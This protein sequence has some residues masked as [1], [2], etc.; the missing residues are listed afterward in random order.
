MLS[1]RQINAGSNQGRGRRLLSHV[2]DLGYRLADLFRPLADAARWPFE[3]AF[4]AIEERVVWPLRERAA[5]RGPSRHATGIGAVAAGGLAAI[6]LAALLLPAGGADRKREGEPVRVAL[7]PPPAAQQQGE[8]PARRELQGPP[9]DF[10]VAGGVSAGEEGAGA[11]GAPAGS[12]SSSS[13]P[14]ATDGSTGAEAPGATAQAGASASLRKPVPAGPAA[15]KVARRFSK[16]F[17]NYE[18][19]RDR[20]AAKQV[21]AATATPR[22]AEALSDRP[23]RLP[24]NSKI[25]KARVVNLVPGPRAGKAYTVSVSLLRVGLTSELR[26]DLLKQGKGKWVVTDVRG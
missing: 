2:A 11:D 5:G 4:W 24:E 26:L 25:P 14:G 3:R 8:R 17:L 16:A 12:A 9:P 20:D 19:G 7:T 21:F 13:A 10:S 22:L 6:L 18:I 1:P 15:M 23:P